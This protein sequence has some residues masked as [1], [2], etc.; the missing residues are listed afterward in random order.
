MGKFSLGSHNGTDEIVKEINKGSGRTKKLQMNIPEEL[1]TRFKLACVAEQTE[2]TEVCV[3]L[4][5]DWLKARG[6]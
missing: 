2:M 1:H 4:L 5:N 6:R 3:Q